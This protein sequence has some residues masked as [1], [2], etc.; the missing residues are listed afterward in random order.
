M[1]ELMRTRVRR[2]SPALFV[3]ILALIV[4]L[5]GSAYAIQRAQSGDSLITKRTLSGNRLRLNT[6]TA[7]EIANATWHPL[8]LVNG[9]A[10]YNTHRAPAWMLDPQGIVHFRGAMTQGSGSVS[11]F[12]TLPARVRPSERLYLT[13]NLNLNNPGRIEVSANGV[14]SVATS[15]VAAGQQFTNLDGVTY[16]VG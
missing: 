3:A 11:V 14:L 7:K 15:T 13:T 10:N 12:A 4:A 2:P 8:N 6:V 5:G 9:W 1:G 16:A